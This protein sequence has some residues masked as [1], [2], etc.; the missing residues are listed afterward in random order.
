MLKIGQRLGAAT[1]LLG[2]VV[3]AGVVWR[4]ARTTEGAV[5]Q[6]YRLP[7]GQVQTLAHNY[8][9]HLEEQPEQAPVVMDFGGAEDGTEPAGFKEWL[10]EMTG[11]DIQAA[12]AQA[13]VL[14]TK[15]V[16]VLRVYFD[17]YTA[18]SRYTKTNVEDFL[19]RAQ[20]ALEKHILQQD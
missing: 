3:L 8:G 2:L 9:V 20:Q 18:T 17:D 12:G 10:A 1:I 6:T 13:D 15:K 5:P 19:C 16:V 4:G 14:G 7:A 11:Q